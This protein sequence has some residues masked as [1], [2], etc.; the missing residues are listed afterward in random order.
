MIQ[1]HLYVNILDSDTQN[2]HKLI[3]MKLFLSL[4]I[5]ISLVDISYGHVWFVLVLDCVSSGS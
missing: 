5:P 3:I 4:S 2:Y 1:G